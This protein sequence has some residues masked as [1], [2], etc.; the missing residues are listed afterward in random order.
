MAGGGVVVVTLAG[1]HRSSDGS[2][3]HEPGHI[4]KTGP[5]NVFQPIFVHSMYVFGAPPEN[6]N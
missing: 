5:A 6:G 2:Y 3:T 4:R 1:P